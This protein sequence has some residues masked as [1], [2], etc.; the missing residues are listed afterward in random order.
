M[1]WLHALSLLLNVALA[2]RYLFDGSPGTN[3]A[4]RGMPLDDAFIHVVYAGSI[5]EEGKFAYNPSEP[6]TGAT[7][8]LWA[9]L[10]ALPFWLERVGLDVSIVEASKG[11]GVLFAVLQGRAACLLA[12]RLHAS[13]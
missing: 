6:E 7:S 9:V 11:H 8:P 13:R 4:L 10:L 2:T 1:A 5:A 12:W 3:A